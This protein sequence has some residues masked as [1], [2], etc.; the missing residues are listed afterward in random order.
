MEL[1]YRLEVMG[2]AD[3][4]DQGERK[5]RGI[6]AVF[7]PQLDL[8]MEAVLAKHGLKRADTGL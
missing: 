1:A 8:S 7:G 2:L 3:R 6:F 4:T 5:Q